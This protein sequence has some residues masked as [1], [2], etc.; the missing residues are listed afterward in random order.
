MGE[1]GDSRRISSLGGSARNSISPVKLG[2]RLV[3]PLGFK[4]WADYGRF[5]AVDYSRLGSGR[6][7]DGL[8]RLGYYLLCKLHALS[9]L[10]LYG[11]SSYVA[12]CHGNPIGE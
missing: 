11:L 5:L 9:S 2:T 3:I 6:L 10:R 1:M 8:R 4:I 7:D 12:C